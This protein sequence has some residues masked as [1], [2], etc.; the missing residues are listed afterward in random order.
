MSGI[1]S[2]ILDKPSLVIGNGESRKD[3][4][5]K[6]LQEK[7]ITV[8]C[9]AL[10]RDFMSDHIVCVDRRMAEEVTNNPATQISKIYVRKDWFHYF[11]KI[12]KNKNI[13]EVPPIPYTGTAREDDPVNWG[14]GPYAL[15]I[16]ATLSDTIFLIGFDLYGN[17]NLL[18]NVYKGTANYAKTESNAVDPAYWIRQIGKTMSRLYH[19]KFVIINEPGWSVP[20]EWKLQNVQFMIVSDFM[21]LVLNTES[22]LDTAVFHGIQPAL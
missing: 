10:H 11:R 1:D 18:N 3:I 15:L 5:L 20:K 22:K 17:H 9:N 4:N 13:V 7:F 14:S 16:G 12:K 2:A 19:K 21:S 6:L 8:G